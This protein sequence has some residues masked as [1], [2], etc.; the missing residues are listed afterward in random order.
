[1]QNLY[2]AQAAVIFEQQVLADVQEGIELVKRVAQHGNPL[3]VHFIEGLQENKEK[4]EQHIQ[5]VLEI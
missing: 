1:V 3:G 2:P 5:F 4:R